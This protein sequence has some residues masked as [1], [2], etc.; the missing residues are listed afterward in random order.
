VHARV[1]AHVWRESSSSSKFRISYILLKKLLNDLP[2]DPDNPSAIAPGL[3]IEGAVRATLNRIALD[4]CHMNLN[5]LAIIMT[6]LRESAK[7]RMAW[8]AFSVLRRSKLAVLLF[9]DFMRDDIHIRHPQPNDVCINY[10]TTTQRYLAD[11]VMGWLIDKSLWLK[12]VKEC[13]NQTTS[14]EALF[15]QGGLDAELQNILPGVHLW[16]RLFD[17]TL[18]SEVEL[19]ICEFAYV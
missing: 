15:F 8:E 7:K 18:P 16:L 5:D 19:L 1:H 11:F 3:T 10:A 9:K 17:V 4:E 14:R 12:V 2:G 13:I 6:G